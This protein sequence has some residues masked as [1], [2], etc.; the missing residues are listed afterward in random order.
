MKNF[1]GRR[2]NQAVTKQKKK[3]ISQ[4]KLEERKKEIDGFMRKEQSL[5]VQRN[6]C[7]SI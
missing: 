1:N 6:I 7:K 4:Q 3:L 2:R 5:E